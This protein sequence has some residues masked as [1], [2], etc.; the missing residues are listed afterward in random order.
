MKRDLQ[1][2]M[3]LQVA[4][5]DIPLTNLWHITVQQIQNQFPSAVILLGGDFNCPGIEW[6]SGSLTDLTSG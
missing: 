6:S 2:M 5:T 3:S 4:Q 1:F